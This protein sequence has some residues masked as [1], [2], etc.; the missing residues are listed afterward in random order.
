MDLRFNIDDY[1]DHTARLERQ[2]IYLRV[3]FKFGKS[4]IE[5]EVEI[6]RLEKELKRAKAIQLEQSI[7]IEMAKRGDLNDE[8][9]GTF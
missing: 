8:L 6:S 2:L 7:K 1:I 9:W 4:S 5:D 3:K